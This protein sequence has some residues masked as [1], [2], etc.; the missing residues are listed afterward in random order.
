MSD[1]KENLF[2][3]MG[4]IAS[5]TNALADVEDDDKR[6]AHDAPT[7]EQQ[8]DGEEREVQEIESLCMRCHEQ[9]SSPWHTFL[10]KQLIL[11]NNAIATNEYP[12]LQGD[13]HHVVQ[14]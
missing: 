8:E 11:G 2:P 13:H 10:G 5:R 1:Q 12:L 3:S 14:M 9:V 7:L 6:L 4:D